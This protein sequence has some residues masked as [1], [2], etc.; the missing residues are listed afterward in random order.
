[1][2]IL[3]IEDE[4]AAARRLRKLVE[5]LQPQ[6]Q[7]LPIQ[8]S[9]EGSIALLEQ[10]PKLDLILLDIHLADGASFEIFRHVQVE[11]PVIFTTAY[12][13]YAID[14]FQVNAV[15]YLLKPIK[16][17]ALAQAFTKLG[18]RQQQ[19]TSINYEQ[20]AR[21]LQPEQEQR[22]LIRLGQQIKLLEVKDIAYA[23][24][25]QRITFFMTKAGRRYPIDYSLE[26]L[27]ELLPERR[28]F[29]IN[30]QFIVALDAIE[31]MLTYSKGRVK[32]ILRPSCDQDTIVSTERSPVF[33]KWLN[34]Y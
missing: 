20:L 31:E 15:D 18:T 8:E 23:Y 30:R 28:F 26:K 21:Q 25:E 22:F 27:E 2:H 3:I 12:D 1:M 29:R 14:A 10:K 17:E 33:K 13:Q 16:R 5:E 24:T 11:T 34:A 7:L 6:A 32:L 9:I 19:A 4:P